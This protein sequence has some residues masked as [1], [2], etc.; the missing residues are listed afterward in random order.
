VYQLAKTGQATGGPIDRLSIAS[1]IAASGAGLARFAI[2]AA[3]NGDGLLEIQVWAVNDDGKPVAV[4]SRVDG[5]ISE[6]ACHAVGPLRVVVAARDAAGKLRLIAYT[7]S[8]NG[9]TLTR[10]GTKAAGAVRGFAMTSMSSD[11]VTVAMHL[12]DRRVVIGTWSLSG[13]HG[14]GNVKSVAVGSGKVKALD[15]AGLLHEFCLI[16]CTD[17]GTLRLRAFKS[18]TALGGDGTG[19]KVRSVAITGVDSFGGYWTA[20]ISKEP[21][22][23]RTGLGGASGR[24][25]LDTGRFELGHWE[26]DN[27]TL[28]SPLTLSASTTIKGMAGIAWELR[29]LEAPMRVVYLL[30]RGAD[31]Y[32]K[33]LAKNQGKPKLRL[34]AFE[35]EGDR[36]ERTA[37]G[38]MGGEHSLVCMARMATLPPH[39]SKADRLMLAARDGKGKL[40]II[41]W[42]A[43]D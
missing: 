34:F 28:G 6:V 13:D 43:T 25:M 10:H 29:V 38:N 20:S 24:L 4:T 42:R 26:F 9:R 8:A 7:V 27:G 21:A 12:E 41:V 15:V 33:L 19:S 32:E 16:A 1:V 2:T 40:K 22:A 31:T 18:P 30:A 39:T 37:Q 14:F 35:R 11:T 5:A 17:T 3:R 36:I 23:V